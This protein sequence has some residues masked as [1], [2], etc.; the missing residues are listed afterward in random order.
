MGE[1]GSWRLIVKDHICA[2][3][4]VHPVGIEKP[5]SAHMIKYWFLETLVMTVMDEI[6]ERLKQVDQLGG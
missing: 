6:K 1:R 3:K 4:N 5:L 2:E